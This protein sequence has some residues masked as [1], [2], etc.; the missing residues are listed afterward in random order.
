MANKT[1]KREPA[2]K[3][4]APQD[5][6]A[7]PNDEVRP[8]SPARPVPMGEFVPKLVTVLT[9]EQDRNDIRGSRYVLNQQGE[10]CAVVLLPPS[11]PY[12]KRFIQIGIAFSLL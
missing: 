2:R 6:V 4:D 5:S 8:E 1:T 3:Q 11:M 10:V 9:L 7:P 12:A